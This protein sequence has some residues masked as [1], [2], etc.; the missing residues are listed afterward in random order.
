[1]DDKISEE[2]IEER[3]NMRHL[4]ISHTDDLLR[5]FQHGDQ[6]FMTKEITKLRTKALLE[7]LEGF[8][9]CVRV[10]LSLWLL[11]TES[12]PEVVLNQINQRLSEEFKKTGEPDGVKNV[13]VIETEGFV[14]RIP[15]DTQKKIETLCP[16]AILPGQPFH[17]TQSPPEWSE[18]L[19]AKCR[20][21]ILAGHRVSSEMAKVAPKGFIR[22][23]IRQ[24]QIPSQAISKQP[25]RTSVRKPKMA[26]GERSS[27][28]EIAEEIGVK[29]TDAMFWRWPGSYGSSKR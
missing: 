10:S 29:P 23:L 14:A 11:S 9:R 19:A 25:K 12:T 3:P 5:E 2:H 4:F 16:S 13:F 28:E 7:T 1:M 18:A 26:K 15:V 22:D 17:P 6:V 8:G 24:R 20:S 21:E 27:R